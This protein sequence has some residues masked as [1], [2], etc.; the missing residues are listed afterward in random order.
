MA[1]TKA[2]KIKSLILQHNRF[3]GG[4]RIADGLNLSQWVSPRG[5]LYSTLDYS[6]AI[7]KHLEK[8]VEK[9]MNLKGD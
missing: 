3:V 1:K 2:D 6:L 8:T 4:F 5:K 9:I 7:N